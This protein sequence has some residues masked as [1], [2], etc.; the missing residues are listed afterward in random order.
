MIDTIDIGSL[1]KKIRLSKKL[2]LKDVAGDYL[3]VSFLSKFERGESEISLS[4]FLCILENLDV[5]IEEIYG[6]FSKDNPTRTEE[7]LARVSKA[8]QQNNIPAL[9]KYYYEEIEKFNST[10]KKIFLY[11]SILIDS[12][13][14]SITGKKMNKKHIEVISDYLFDVDQWGKRELVIL[15]NSM[16][17]V[18]TNTLNLLIKEIIYKTTLFGNNEENKKIKIDLILNGISIFL[19]RKELNYAKFYIDLF[20]TLTIPEVYLYERVEYNILIGTY[21]ILIGKIEVGK[22]KIELALESLKNLGA[23]N[24][25]LMRENEYEELLNSI[26]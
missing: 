20:D 12:F 6:T 4:R 9:K 10:Q 3:S 17:A 11:N 21:W 23:E 26:I 14:I 1:T 25:L 24:L 5:S 2:S 8:F 22:K 13:L 16:S 7:L 18:P 19:E 15:G